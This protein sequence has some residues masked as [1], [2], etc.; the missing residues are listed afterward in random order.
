MAKVK[1]ILDTRSK[2]K[3]GVYPVKI[4]LSHKGKNTYLGMGVD[5]EKDYF[6]NGKILKC[7]KYPSVTRVNNTLSK[8]LSTAQDFIDNLHDTQRIHAITL[9]KIKEEIEK[10]FSDN[11]TAKTFTDYYNHFLTTKTERTLEMYERTRKDLNKFTNDTIFFEELN[12]AWLNKFNSYLTQRGNCQ[13]TRSIA[14]RNIRAVF[15]AAMKEEV[16]SRDLYP[17]Y[18]YSIP[19]ASTKKKGMTSEL[20]RKIYS[21][22][23]PE[24]SYLDFTVDTFLL[25]FLLIGINNKDLFNIIQLSPTGRIEYVRAKTKK[26]YSIQP[27]S[28]VL[29]LM[30]KW[31]GKDKLF[32]YADRYKDH[33]SMT[34]NIN[35]QLKIIGQAIGI[36]DLTMYHARHTWATIA[37]SLDIP[38]EVIAAGLGHGSNTVTDIYINFDYKKVDAANKK[39]IDHIGVFN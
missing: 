38:K 1:L 10:K 13:S 8:R 7:K 37:S 25:S 36:P 6:N 35:K 34:K 32:C 27:H 3:D 26:P 17:F 21:M 18:N 15:N 4:R 16:V 20:I 14:L 39:I 31:K 28:Y 33:I 9:Q 23:F 24:R 19:K 5:V 11:R 22:D 12:T 29:Y 2:K 30:H